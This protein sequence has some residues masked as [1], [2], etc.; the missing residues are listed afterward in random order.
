M[1]SKK[2]LKL[3]AVG[4]AVVAITLGLGLGLGLKK[5]NTNDKSLAASSAEETYDVYSDGCR[6]ELDAT[7]RLLSAPSNDAFQGDRR[8]LRTDAIRQLSKGSKSK[9][10]SGA[11]YNVSSHRVCVNLVT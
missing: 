8:A 7:G 4:L 6:R 1:V 3:G 5:N 11:S 9:G 2:A 10:S